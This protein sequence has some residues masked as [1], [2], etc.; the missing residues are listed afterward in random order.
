MRSF[1]VIV[2]GVALLGGAV[3]ANGEES[4]DLREQVRQLQRQ[5]DSLQQ[6]LQQ[7]Q[8]IIHSLDQRL[9]ELQAT[10]KKASAETSATILAAPAERQGLTPRRKRDSAPKSN[11]LL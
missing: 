11:F 6:Q 3:C 2:C 8:Q 7:Q 4:P 5:N 9:T 1:G 10:T